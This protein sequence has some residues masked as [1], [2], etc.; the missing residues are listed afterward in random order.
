MRHAHQGRQVHTSGHAGGFQE[1]VPSD[2]DDLYRRRDRHDAYGVRNRHGSGT[3]FQL[4]C[5]TGGRSG[6]FLYPDGVPD[7]GSVLQICKR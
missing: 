7:P 5:G 4:R 6:L 2:R 1:Q 3:A